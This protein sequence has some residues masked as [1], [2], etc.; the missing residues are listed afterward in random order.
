MKWTKYQRKACANQTPFW[1]KDNWLKKDKRYKSFKTKK[2]KLGFYPFEIWNLDTTIVY[3]ILPRLVLFREHLI[4]VPYGLT[5]QEW[6]DK[7]DTYIS[8]LQKYLSDD[9]NYNDI[10]PILHDFIE[11]FPALWN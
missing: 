8:A 6:A 3:F 11:W 2:K 9:C 4:S 7:L 1:L 10:K 5:K